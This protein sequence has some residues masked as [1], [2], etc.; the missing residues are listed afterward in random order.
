[1]NE[2]DA[3]GAKA[4]SMTHIAEL[5]GGR[6]RGDGGVVVSGVA[7]LEDAGPGDIALL[8]GRRYV[9]FVDG[10]SA[11]A[12]LVSSAL[13]A[14]LPDDRPRV[15]VDDASG[16]LLTLLSH[17]HPPEREPAR[18]HPT[19]VLG[20]GVRLGAD[21]GIGA[22][23]VLGDGA[24]V[25]DGTRIGPHVVVG[26]GARIGI[27]CTLHPQVVLYPGVVI[28]DRVVLHSGARLG[29]D[30]FGYVFMDGAHRK[31]PHPGGCH[32]GD[33][34]EVGANTTIDRGSV[35]NTVIGQG[36]KLDNLVQIAHNVHVGE[37][38]L[39]AAMVGIAGSTRVGKGVWLGGQA[40]LINQLEIG[41]GARIAVAARVMR[42]VPAGETVSGHP[43]RPHRE[44]LQR[45]AAAA[46][47]PEL[48]R[49]VRAL[50]AELERMREALGS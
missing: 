45:Q 4:L 28:G 37:L 2:H 25:G 33:D 42:D 24:I 22:Y 10:C 41:D 34:V 48:L 17:F 21:V 20:A 26:T 29:S 14:R 38:S 3:D 39:V 7:P 30:G 12:F 16:A 47:T 32:V 35:G 8:S 1:M 5:T 6:L 27:E 13:E 11:G 23:T 50:E 31:L 36:V 46:K 49:R 19:A 15:V 44:D 40:G 9:K 43:S 18:I